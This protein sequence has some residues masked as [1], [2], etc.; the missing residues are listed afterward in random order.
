VPNG[1][2]RRAPVGELRRGGR[3][4]FLQC[5]HGS[6]GGADW[7]PVLCGRQQRV[8]FRQ[9]HVVNYAQN[10]NGFFE[11]G[12]GGGG[13]AQNIKVAYNVINNTNGGVCFNQG[14][15]NIS[16][17]N[18]KFENNT[19]VA[20]SG[21]TGYR[22]LDCTNDYSAVQMR[23]NIFYSNLQIANNGNFTHSNNLYY[24][25][26]MVNG[27]GVGYSLGTGEIST[28]PLFVNM[29]GGDFHLQITSPAIDTGMD[30]GYD[31]D[32][33]DHPVPQALASLRPDMGAY[34][35]GAGR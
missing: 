15:Y 11:L 24:T 2:V 30:L 23:N 13:S 17:A 29:A 18:F 9:R 7:P 19:Y 14:S 33:E 10:T 35:Y 21:S 26:N 25:V 20:T 8:R 22:V 3:R 27:S 6:N 16:V 34:E 32:I 12:A 28:S 31:K 4:R 5:L 1:H